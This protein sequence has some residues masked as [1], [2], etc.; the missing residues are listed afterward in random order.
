MSESHV[1]GCPLTL[2]RCPMAHEPH[3]SAPH[4]AA[5]RQHDGH[6]HRRAEPGAS[7][8]M[9]TA[10]CEPRPVCRQVGAHTGL[11]MRTAQGTC[12]WMGDGGWAWMGRGRTQI[13]PAHARR[14][15]IPFPRL[16]PPHC[17]SQM[18]GDPGQQ[19]RRARSGTP[20]AVLGAG[21][22]SVAWWP[23]SACCDAHVVMTL[24]LP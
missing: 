5:A 2:G 13:A 22:G 12:G 15:R 9:R 18:A 7:G 23:A 11:R 1:G 20:Q 17:R 6:V 10:N 24:S 21:A 4:T 16:A 14:E 19:L 8:T 3:V